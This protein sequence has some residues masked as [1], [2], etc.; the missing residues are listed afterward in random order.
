M[1]HRGHWNSCVIHKIHR[2]YSWRS[3]AAW[4][5]LFHSSRY[6]V[7]RVSMTRI[8]EKMIRWDLIG[9]SSFMTLRI[10][11]P[12]QGGLTTSLYLCVTHCI[13]SDCTATR[14]SVRPTMNEHR[15]ASDVHVPPR[16]TPR[17]SHRGASLPRVI[18]S[19]PLTS[20]AEMCVWRQFTSE[21]CATKKISH[22]EIF[23]KLF[24]LY[25]RVI[26][27]IRSRLLS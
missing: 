12:E 18:T 27:S 20:Q 11:S 24:T 6:K 22:E 9:V 21:A 23:H 15:W 10:S 2:T 19:C 16:N 14:N 17:V 8:R 13:K 1:R 26:Y 25:S 7:F 3:N 4:L 5:K